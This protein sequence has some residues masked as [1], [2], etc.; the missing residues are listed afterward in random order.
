[1]ALQEEGL[2]VSW[3]PSLGEHIKGWWAG[4]PKKWALP[5][6][7]SCLSLPS[8]PERGPQLH[9][10]LDF[11]LQ[12]KVPG[13]FSGE[14]SLLWGVRGQT[15]LPTQ[16]DLNSRTSLGQVPFLG[17]EAFHRSF[18]QSLPK[19][20]WARRCCLRPYWACSQA[21]I[22]MPQ[23]RGPF[24]GQE[25]SRNKG[26]EGLGG[27]LGSPNS[28]SHFIGEETE[29]RTCPRSWSSVMQPGWRSGVLTLYRDLLPSHQTH[30][31]PP[32]DQHVP[33]QTR[34]LSCPTWGTCLSVALQG[35]G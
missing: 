5:L 21:L 19:A 22:P 3:W 18:I 33:E 12:H 4:D 26:L 25:I 27:H 2:G 29:G 13:V 7:L 15:G 23:S 34:T 16:R 20:T 1:M 24:C 30:M 32:R 8:T 14:Y 10:H 28:P 6:G 9:L 35:G 17:P 11:R 31:S